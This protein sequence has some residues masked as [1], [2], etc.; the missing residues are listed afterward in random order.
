MFKNLFKQL[1]SNITPILEP[2]ISSESVIFE[3]TTDTSG[4]EDVI[5]RASGLKR[6][7]QII[8]CF[9]ALTPYFESGLLL[10]S[11]KNSQNLFELTPVH[12]FHQGIPFVLTE[13]ENKVLLQTPEM[14]LIQINRINDKTLKDKLLATGWLRS[15]ED[16]LLIFRPDQYFWIMVSSKLPDLWLKPHVEKIQSRINLVLSEDGF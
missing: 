5:F 12:S 3:A 8:S 1:E 10:K 6:E 15:L 2:K 16:Q 7:E 9:T 4:L 13:D 14:T 11:Q